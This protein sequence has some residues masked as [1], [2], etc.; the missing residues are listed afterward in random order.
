[1]GMGHHGGS[2]GPSMGG[3][4]GGS[5]IGPSMGGHHG[6]STGPSMGGHHG[7]SG[8]YYGGSGGHHDGGGGYYGGSSGRYYRSGSGFGFYLG[9]PYGLGYSSYGLYGSPFGYYARSYYPYTY[10]SPYYGVSSYASF[11]PYGYNTAYPPTNNNNPPAV[12]QTAQTA[13]TSLISSSSPAATEFQAVAELAFREHHPEEAERLSRHAIVEDEKNGKLHLFSAQ[14]R[15]A[16]GDYS[17]AAREVRQAVGLLDRSE[18]GYVVQNYKD[19]YRGQDFVTQMEKLVQ[20]CRDNPQ[21][22]DAHFLR[23]YQYAYLGHH[24]SSRAMLT[25]AMMLDPQDRVAA[26][27]LT[28]LPAEAA[29][30]PADVS[31]ENAPAAISPPPSLGQGVPTNPTSVEPLP[32]PLTSTSP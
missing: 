9:I 2:I 6:G 28:T 29:A 30:P 15:F 4:H 25:K 7:G 12:D 22:A 11:Q 32:L 13:T 16:I 31:G 23:G 24:T 3:H 19:F 18:W 10:S 17:G 27:I 1:M 20:F 14:T 26:E 5:S 8:G 21:S